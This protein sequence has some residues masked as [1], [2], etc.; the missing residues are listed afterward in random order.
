LE[1][2]LSRR[3][4]AEYKDRLKQGLQTDTKTSAKHKKSKATKVALYKTTENQPVIAVC[5]N[6]CTQAAFSNFIK[7]H[8]ETPLLMFKFSKTALFHHRVF[9][10]AGYWMQS[11][12]IYGRSKRNDPLINWQRQY[13]ERSL[14]EQKIGPKYWKIA[15][16]IHLK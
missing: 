13:V 5:E 9:V 10:D 6:T 14:R 7:E 12:G 4:L 11:G 2:H 8:S 15:D 16:I 3:L 1:P